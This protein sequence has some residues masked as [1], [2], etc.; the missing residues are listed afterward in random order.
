MLARSLHAPIA[1]SCRA[2]CSA[3]ISSRLCAAACCRRANRQYF[4][5]DGGHW[6]DL[7]CHL[8]HLSQGHQAVSDTAGEWRLSYCVMTNACICNLMTADNFVDAHAVPGQC[9]IQAARDGVD[10]APPNLVRYKACAFC[11][12][13]CPVRHCTFTSLRT[14]CGKGSVLHHAA[15]AGSCPS[16]L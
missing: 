4:V 5:L 16:S 1:D 9:H 10:R 12:P 6:C 11:L 15:G 7:L 2:P 13:C 3:A 14:T 8:H